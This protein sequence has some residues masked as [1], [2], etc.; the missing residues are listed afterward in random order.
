MLRL[1]QQYFYASAT[2]QDIVRRFKKYK[3]H[4][5]EDFDKKNSIHLNETHGAIIIVEMLRILYDEYK[6]N[7]QE[8]WNAVYHTFS[9]GFFFI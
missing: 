5:F 6:L 3:D 4:K 2:L 1:K 7:W 9:C 8:A